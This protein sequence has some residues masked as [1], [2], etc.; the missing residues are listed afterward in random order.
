VPKP[1]RRERDKKND[2]PTQ[3]NLN[4]GQIPRFDTEAE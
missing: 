3:R 4:E 1:N 2:D